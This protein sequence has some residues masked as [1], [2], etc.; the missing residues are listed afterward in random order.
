MFPESPV[1]PSAPAGGLVRSC[2]HRG[3]ALTTATWGSKDLTH[4]PLPPSLRLCLL[5]WGH[6]GEAGP[7]IEKRDNLSNFIINKSSHRALYNPG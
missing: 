4:L 5:S 3:P 2:A 7:L 1:F 6:V